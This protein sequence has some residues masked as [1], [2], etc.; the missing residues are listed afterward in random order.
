WQNVLIA[1]CKQA[2]NPRLPQLDPPS[3]F[4]KALRIAQETSFFGAIPDH[5]AKPLPQINAAAADDLALWVG[6]EGGFAPEEEEA[7]RQ[8]S[9]QALTLGGCV[10]RVETA[11][12]ALLGMIH[13]L[14][15]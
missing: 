14:L 10:L 7:L 4:Q 2:I 1:A 3:D 12:P 9:C 11:V 6:P 8:A 15:K 13:G 5:P